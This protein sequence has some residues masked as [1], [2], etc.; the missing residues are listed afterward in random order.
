M[1][2][3][4]NYTEIT[5]NDFYE[6]AVENDVDMMNLQIWGMRPEAEII[7]RHFEKYL[8]EIGDIIVDASIR[9]D[10]NCCTYGIIRFCY[11][12]NLFMILNEIA[13]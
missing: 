11:T 4:A 1:K 5:V 3:I 9:V 12:K 2:T 13:R 10:E 7:P 8:P 6:Y